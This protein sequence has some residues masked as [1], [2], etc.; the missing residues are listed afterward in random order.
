MRSNDS[1]LVPVDGARSTSEPRTNVSA[2][3]YHS[4]DRMSDTQLFGS[5]DLLNTGWDFGTYAYIGP[6]GSLCA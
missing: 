2:D 6:G 1:D 5:N 3:T 4:D